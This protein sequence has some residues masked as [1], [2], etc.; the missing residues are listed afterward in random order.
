VEWSEKKLSDGQSF[1]NCEE[2]KHR[3]CAGF[4][5]YKFQNNCTFDLF[6]SNE[7][8]AEESF[9][10][11]LECVAF[12]MTEFWKDSVRWRLQTVRGRFQSVRNKSKVQLFWNL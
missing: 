12:Y 10:N 3:N 6:S 4:F 11:V 7:Q 5:Y 1:F 9:Q 2:N 8:S